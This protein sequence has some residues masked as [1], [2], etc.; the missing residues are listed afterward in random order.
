MRMLMK[1]IVTGLLSGVVLGGTL[2][3]AQAL[4]GKEVYVLLL[5]VDYIPGLRDLQM[6]E[7]EEFLL[8]LTVSVILVPVLYFLLKRI[9]IHRKIYPYI[10]INVLIGG[11]LF[12]TTALSQRTPH[13]TDFPALIFWLA[14]HLIYGGIAGTI[15]YYIGLDSDEN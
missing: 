10:L 9:N 7:A 11:I 8:H 4:S 6:N 14:G 12:C 2:K 15:I 5:N 1:L 3:L 13:I